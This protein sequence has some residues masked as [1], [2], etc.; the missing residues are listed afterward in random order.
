[1]ISLA[2]AYGT[3][4]AIDLFKFMAQYS[5]N[6]AKFFYHQSKSFGKCNYYYKINFINK[7]FIK[8]QIFFIHLRR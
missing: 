8:I 5:Y 6:A 4:A 1:M 2:A 3:P 7:C